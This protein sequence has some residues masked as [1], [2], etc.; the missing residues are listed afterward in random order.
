MFNAEVPEEDILG[1]LQRLE[2]KFLAEEFSF[3]LYRRAGAY[4]S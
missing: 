4:R 1:A 3:Q 2:E